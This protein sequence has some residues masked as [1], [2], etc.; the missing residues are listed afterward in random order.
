M[1]CRMSEIGNKKKQMLGG[2]KRRGRHGGTHLPR[3]VEISGSGENI[4]DIMRR[5]TGQKNTSSIVLVFTFNG[6]PSDRAFSCV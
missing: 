1:F 6:I 2:I 3:N 4:D 5:M